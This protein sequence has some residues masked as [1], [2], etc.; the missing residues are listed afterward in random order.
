MSTVYHMAHY[1]RFDFGKA[2]LKGASLE[3]LCRSALAVT[4]ASG[5][6]LWERAQDRL[7]DLADA[8]ARQ[9][10]LNKVADLSSAV[11]GEM[12]LVQSGDLQALLDLK[13][14][15]VQLSKI[16]TAEIFNLDERTAPAGSQFIRG[17][18]YWLAIGNHI[19]LVKT[20]SMTV[21]QVHAY[22]DWLLKKRTSTIAEDIAF[23]LRAELDRSQVA[24]DIGEIRGLRVSGK[25]A[26][27]M[28]VTA[29]AP[30]E[31]EGR[32][33]RTSR[34]VAAKFVEFGRAVPIVEALLG[35]A[36]TDSLVKSLGE[37]EYLA[38]DASVK[39]KGRR[40]AATR[41]QLHNIANDLD[42]MTDAK[43]QIEGKDGKISDGDAILRTRMPFYLPHEGSNL[44]EFDNVSD[45]LQEVYARFVRDGKIKA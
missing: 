31:H 8:S 20:Q 29:P 9:I 36:S 34:T 16:T 35:K 19:F 13:A 18:A 17:M 40:T 7:F 37:N 12:C 2:D 42:D 14:S 26:P 33:K 21:D 22:L 41:A 32:L 3:S 4:D 28:A 39:V 10:L 1:R 23:S 43:V 5:A 44:L 25:A 15:K 6:T 11:F 24:G 30:D 45:Q 38:V 27:Q